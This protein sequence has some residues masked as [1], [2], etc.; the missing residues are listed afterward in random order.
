MKYLKEYEVSPLITGLKI[1]SVKKVIDADEGIEITFDNGLILNI[2][3]TCD[4]GGMWF[5]L[6]K[7]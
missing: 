5:G 3:Y 2:G 7:R 6:S 4:H 1:I